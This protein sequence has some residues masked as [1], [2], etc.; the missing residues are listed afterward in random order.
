MNPEM[1][2]HKLFREK[3]RSKVAWS[4]EWNESVFRLNHPDGH[5]VLQA[6]SAQAHRLVGIQELFSGRK[7]I[8]ETPEGLLAFKRQKVAARELRALVEAGLRSDPDYRQQVKAQ[9]RRAIRLG[10]SLFFGGGIPFGLYCWWAFRAPSP[11]P[12]F[13]LSV[14]WLIHLVLLLLLGCTLGGAGGACWGISQLTRIRRIEEVP[15]SHK[16]YR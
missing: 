9:G 7:V 8:L 16:Q 15:S 6:N 14:G 10:L 13:M 11:P 5:T 2:S 12:G 4:L 3:D 1:H